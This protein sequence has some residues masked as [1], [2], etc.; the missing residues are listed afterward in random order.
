MRSLMLIFAAAS[1]TLTAT[2][3]AQELE[4]R[5][6]SPGPTGMNIVAVSGGYS[7]GDLVFDS[8][9]PIVGATA[10][11]YTAGAGYQ[12]FFGLAGK[13]AK[14]AVLVGSADCNARG[15]VQ[16]QYHERH[17]RGLTDPRIG[18]SWIFYGAPAMTPQQYA[19]YRPATLAGISIAVSPPLGQYDNTKLLN[20][21]TNR[22]TVRTQIG[23]ARY[24]GRWTL[25]GTLGA[26]FF[27]DNHEF[28]GNSTQSQQPIESLQVHAGYTIRPQLW[29]AASATYF[30][31]GGT[32][33]DDVPRPGFQSNS[34]YGVTASMPVARGQSVNLNYSRGLF[35][36]TGSNYDTVIVGWGIRWF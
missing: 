15:I 8:S 31:G 7:T 33:I 34:R 16:D 28:M 11:T 22:W 35:T 6:F 12:R 27:T 18:M 4:P 24:R 26:N 5:A 13:T 20:A 1:L 21:G 14:I 10:D 30:R 29:I 2:A 9:L 23:V 25:E 17:F 19:K 36:K 3:R 32:A